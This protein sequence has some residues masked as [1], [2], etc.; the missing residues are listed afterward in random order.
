MELEFD[1]EIDA[2]LRK[3]SRGQA[4]VTSAHLE[5][6]EIAAF[7]ENAL[8]PTAR[9]FYTKHLA[10]CDRCRTVLGQTISLYPEA[11]IEAASSPVTTGAISEIQIPWYR[12]LFAIPNMAA[13]M[14][15]LVL[16]FAGLLAYLVYQGNFGTKNSDVAKLNEP[17]PL[18]KSVSEP[19]FSG[20]ANAASN[21]SNTESNTASPVITSG[22]SPM[23]KTLGQEDPNQ[24][25]IGGDDRRDATSEKN[26]LRGDSPEPPPSLAPMTNAP[27]AKEEQKKAEID[28]LKTA[29]KRREDSDL[30]KSAASTDSVTESNIKQPKD[31]GVVNSAQAQNNVGGGVFKSKSGPYRNQQEQRSTLPNTRARDDEDKDTPNR[32]VAGRSFEKKDGVWY[33]SSY[34]GQPT[35]NIRRGTG[36]FKILDSG[37]QNIAN[38]MSGTVVVVWKEKAYRIQ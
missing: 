19:S 14:G 32:K 26:Q 15:A 27:A 5:A 2:I 31:E 28:D 22:G 24:P 6:D 23:T 1:K 10:D 25:V 12:K 29:G 18:S 30:A 38:S 13:S 33:D 21:S 16:V 36:E 3:S 37:L 35:I 9:A 4:T 7:A 20:S 8:P 17:Q 34:R 11:E